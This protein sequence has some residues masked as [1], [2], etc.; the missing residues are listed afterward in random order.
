MRA[1]VDAKEFSQALNQVI[2]VIKQSSVPELEGVLVQIR[3]GRCTLTATDFT[4]WLTAAIPASGDE[5]G[6][7]FQRPKDAARACGHFAEELALETAE[8][9][10]GRKRWLRLTMS[11]GSRAARLMAFPPED[12]PAMPAE[13]ARHTY[14]VNA[15]RLLERVEHVRYMLNKP[16][17]STRAQNTHVQFSGSKVFALDGCRLACDVDDSLSVRQPFMA[18][19]E[20]LG[21]LKFFG[22]Q[23]ITAQMGERYLQLTDGTATV[24]TRLD[25][26]L[27]FN[28]DGAVPRVFLEEFY[29]SP[30]NVL[31]ELDY[32]KK[33]AGNTGKV[34]V[35]F[36]NGKLSMT[37]AG[38]SFSTQVRV[39]GTSG[40]S[41]GFALGYMTDA[42]RQ[43]RG[44]ERVK[45]KVSSPVAPI[46]LE[47]EGRS[48]FAMVL[49][50]RIKAERAAA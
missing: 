26:P 8:E 21:Y 2:K 9:S 40:I 49:P 1:T 47:A 22:K 12:Y 17:P 23:E 6:F 14:T 48:D 36:S 42:L 33:L 44:E 16:G 32:L 41:F 27:V 18:L 7:V 34:N 4:T 50:V 43:F 35:R 19:P 31:D 38:G 20:A 25:G 46:V 24:L 11:C 5:L 10:A 3:D 37:A 28:V 39:E 13:Q 29:V 15:A 30:K 45:V